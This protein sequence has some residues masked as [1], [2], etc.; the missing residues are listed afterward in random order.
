MSVDKTTLIQ[1][2]Q[3]DCKYRWLHFRL[4]EE[5][6]TEFIRRAY[7]ESKLPRTRFILDANLRRL[8]NL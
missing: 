2:L 5:Y 8:M 6:P 4:T 7:R 3:H 1:Q